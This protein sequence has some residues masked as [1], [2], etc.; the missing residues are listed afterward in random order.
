MEALQ[1]KESK[2]GADS[3]DDSPGP[4]TPQ[5]QTPL[6]NLTNSNSLSNLTQQQNPL[7][8]AY[9]INGTHNGAGLQPT[10]NSLDF[11]GIAQIFNNPMFL[12]NQYGGSMVG[13]GLPNAAASLA[14]S[15]A[16]STSS[17]RPPQQ[18]LPVTQKQP[19]AAPPPLQPKVHHQVN[20]DIYCLTFIFRT[21]HALRQ[22]QPS[23]PTLVILITWIVSCRMDAMD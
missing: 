10:Q 3:D 14:S 12:N 15:L 9:A 2:Q 5:Q 8:A 1:R 11:N 16:S 22:P 19:Q 23:E 13:Q 4:S 18:H 7:A 21:L 20:P 6:L 17:N